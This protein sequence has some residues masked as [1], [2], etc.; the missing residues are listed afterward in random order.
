MSTTVKSILDRFSFTLNDATHV[1]WTDAEFKEWIN[2]GQVE[3]VEKNPTANSENVVVPMVVGSKQSLGV[4]GMLLA[5]VVRNASGPTITM[6]SHEAL[7]VANPDWMAGT[8]TTNVSHYNKDSREKR[9]F[10]AYPPNDGNGSV[11]VL[12]ASYPVAIT[13]SASD[14]ISLPDEY[15][16]VILDYCFY[17]AYSKDDEAGEMKKA[18]MHYQAFTV[19]LGGGGA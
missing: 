14:N 9:V 10:Y 3:I 15:A 8:T 18:G 11:E 4:T 5:N 6:V 13:D 17:R 2:A 1:R 12:Q 16:D 19:G 7:S